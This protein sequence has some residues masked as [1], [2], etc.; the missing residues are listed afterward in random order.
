MGA[1]KMMLTTTD[2]WVVIVFEDAGDPSY[3]K[4]PFEC[5]RAAL[6]WAESSPD[7]ADGCV[8]TVLKA[9]EK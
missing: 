2:T 5:Y 7:C 8:I 4:G 9:V 3:V 6:D 1:P